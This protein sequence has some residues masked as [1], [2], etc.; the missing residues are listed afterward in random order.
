MLRWRYS[1]L[2]LDDVFVPLGGLTDNSP[3]TGIE[4]IMIARENR[5]GLP[6]E[7]RLRTLLFHIISGFLA[8]GR[9][10]A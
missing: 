1:R 5:G 8:V 3:F 10:L 6:D 9:G 2:G 7:N 4:S